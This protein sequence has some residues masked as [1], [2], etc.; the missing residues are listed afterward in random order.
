[1]MMHY[2]LQDDAKNSSK[3]TWMRCGHG[4]KRLFCKATQVLI[5]EGQSRVSSSAQQTKELS[6]RSSF[7]KRASLV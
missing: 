6:K 4:Q 2:S 1:M 7:H 3:N 5:F